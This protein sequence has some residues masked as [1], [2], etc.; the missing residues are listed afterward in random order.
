MG[1]RRRPA[2]V[3]GGETTVL[4]KIYGSAGS[5]EVETLVDTGATFTKIP[6]NMVDEIGLEVKYETSVE[7]GDGTIIT[8]QLALADVEVEGV[9]RPMLV[10]V[11]D[12]TETP[13]L[14]Y[15]TLEILGFKV[16]PVTRSLEKTP[17]IEY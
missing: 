12:G 1:G 6:R 17:A 13:L 9:R 8:R 3:T 10:A 16:N 15:T 2:G 11:F 14:G 7:L 4:M 5:A